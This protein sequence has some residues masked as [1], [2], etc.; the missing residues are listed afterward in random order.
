MGIFWITIWYLVCAAFIGYFIFIFR[1]INMPRW[2][3]DHGDI[4]SE[5]GYFEDPTGKILVG[6]FAEDEG[7]EEAKQSAPHVQAPS[8]DIGT[9]VI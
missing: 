4:T 2:R 1:L 3:D 9:G 5:V 7:P 8:S 6:Q